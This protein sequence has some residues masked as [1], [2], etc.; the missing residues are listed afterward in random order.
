MTPVP[1]QGRLEASLTGWVPP[2]PV[3]LGGFFFGNQTTFGTDF[4]LC[5]VAST[6]TLT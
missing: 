1:F 6:V 3:E 5:S 4:V 2:H